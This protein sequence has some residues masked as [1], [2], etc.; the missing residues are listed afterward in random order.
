M[1]GRRGW[2]C[3][4]AGQQLVAITDALPVDD[5]RDSAEELVIY[6]VALASMYVKKVGIGHQSNTAGRSQVDCL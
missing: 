1:T 4:D 5:G 3:G 2:R 6:R